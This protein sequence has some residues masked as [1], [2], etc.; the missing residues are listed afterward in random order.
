M[1]E[2]IRS[3]Y[4]R[5]EPHATLDGS[6][7][8]ELMHPSTQGNVRQSLAEATIAPGGST[9]LHRHRVTEEIHHFTHGQGRMT[10]GVS[11]FDIGPGDT[12]CIE[13][14]AAHRVENTGTQALRMLCARAPAY[15]HE[16]TELL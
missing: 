1:T 14:D 12:V 5:I 7:I 2:P 16:D 11:V 15:A 13:P 4:A 3:T 8:R 9:L 10:L 6:L